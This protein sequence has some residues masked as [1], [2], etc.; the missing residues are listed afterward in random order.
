[1]YEGARYL[2]RL[3]VDDV[4]AV[5][6]EGDGSVSVPV[7]ENDPSIQQSQRPA[8]SRPQTGRMSIDLSAKASTRA[9]ILVAVADKFYVLSAFSGLIE[10][11]IT[12]SCWQRPKMEADHDSFYRRYSCRFYMDTFNRVFTPK[13]LRIRFVFPEGK[14]P[15][16]NEKTNRDLVCELTILFFSYRHDSDQ[17]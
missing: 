8:S 7:N 10:Y 3:L 16:I 6:R 17:Q 2:D 12:I 5:K 14:T 1:M 13:T 9:A 15:N 4:D 11:V